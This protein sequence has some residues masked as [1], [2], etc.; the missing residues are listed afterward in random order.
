MI[1]NIEITPEGVVYEFGDDAPEDAYEQL[2]VAGYPTNP[3]TAKRIL[4]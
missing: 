4:S 2:A 1:E 3:T